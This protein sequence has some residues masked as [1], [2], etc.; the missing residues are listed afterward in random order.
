MNEK[1]FGYLNTKPELYE[2]GEPLFWDD[3]HISEGMLEAHLDPEFEGATRNFVFVFRSADW[4]AKLASNIDHPK[5]LDLGCGPGI[6]AEQFQKRGFEVTG[7]DFSKR[8][9]E[10]A[11]DSA[12]HQGYP[13]EYIYMDYLKLDIHQKFDVATLI[14]CDYGVLSPADRKI[15]LSKVRDALKP[16]GI[17]IL[18]TFTPTNYIDYKEERK[19]AYRNSGFWSAEPH[20]LV[21]TNYRYPSDTFLE[22][23]LVL[24]EHDLK[25][26]HNWNQAF[27][28]DSLSKELTEEGFK[29][30]ELFAN[31]VGDPYEAQS[32]TV[33]IVCHN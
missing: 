16:G 7:I 32:D 11:K 24:T 23:Y 15:V 9:I 33:C 28:P 30:L 27:T 4:I 3:E 5:L 14:Y 22:Q 29:N 20:L 19:T 10:Y 26:Y 17:F 21:Q 2:S 31:V 18:D 8:S 25:R 1:L 13:I 12:K 6:Y